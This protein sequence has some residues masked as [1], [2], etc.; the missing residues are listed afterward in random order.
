MTK[1]KSTALPN[2]WLS[3]LFRCSAAPQ[4]QL[5]AVPVDAAPLHLPH[6]LD[7]LLLVSP[8]SVMGGL[9]FKEHL[10]EALSTQHSITIPATASWLPHPP[11]R[12][13]N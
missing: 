9:L 8:Q 3:P 11:H 12:A 5:R 4:E 6:R 13:C 10:L 7:W 2:L 1:G